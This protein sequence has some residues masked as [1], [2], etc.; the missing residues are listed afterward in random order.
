MEWLQRILFKQQLNHNS[1]KAGFVN[2]DT[3]K[4]IALVLHTPLSTSKNELDRWITQ[5]N[6][7]VDVIYC[8]PNAKQASF[9]DWQCLTKEK[10]SWTG[11]PKSDALVGLASKSY[12][13]VICPSKTLNYFE[14]SVVAAL[15]AKTKISGLEH[16]PFYSLTISHEGIASS[17]LYMDT[18]VKYL[19]MIREN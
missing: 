16:L 2:W 14:Q 3:V 13:V 7:R 1:S 10:S 6:K 11:L 8:E 17:L 15:K 9:A 12:D 4:D 18:C 19:S 5:S